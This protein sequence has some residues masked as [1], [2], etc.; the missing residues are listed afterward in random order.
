ML[1]RLI[2]FNTQED[3]DMY[4]EVLDKIS[5]GGNIVVTLKQASENPDGSYKYVDVRQVVSDVTPLIQMND[6]FFYVTARDM[7]KLESRKIAQ[8]WELYLQRGTKNFTEGK[9]ND[10]LLVIDIAKNELS[11]GHIYCLSAVAPAFAGMDVSHNFTFLFSVDD[12]RCTKDN[13]S[14]YDVEYEA[15]LREESGDEVH[16][17]NSYEDEELG[18]ITDKDL[19]DEFDENDGFVDTSEFTDVNA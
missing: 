6:T 14:I 17:F 10:Y 11:E 9:P 18:D 13:I 4:K 1:K 15:S 7:R 3:F 16:K 12:V 2:D 5:N 8:L 19:E